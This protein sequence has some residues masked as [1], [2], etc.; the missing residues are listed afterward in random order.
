MPASSLEVLPVTMGGFL[1]LVDEHRLARDEKKD[2]EDFR[3]LITKMHELGRASAVW[4]WQMRMKMG[5][6]EAL[7]TAG[8]DAGGRHEALMLEMLGL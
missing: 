3:F 7:K 5:N 2:L 1:E 4:C 6:L 8:E